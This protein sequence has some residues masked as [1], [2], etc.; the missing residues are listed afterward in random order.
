MFGS[1][2]PNPRRALRLQNKGDK[3]FQ[4]E[5]FERALEFY[6]KS[7]KWNPER[8]EIYRKLNSTLE[9]ID[10]E[11]SQEDFEES[12]SWT[13]RQQE[14]ENP[15]LKW[16]YQK[17]SVEYQNI[18]KL[19]R[20]LMLINN[21]EEEQKILVQILEYEEKAALPL[22]DFLLSMKIAAHKGPE[23]PAEEP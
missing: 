15:E 12:L 14:L 9:K 17:F 11:W 23:E 16:V 13:M 10:R 6:R 18:H 19:L 2:I 20:Q 21:P 22:L 5:K 4:N 1:K 8:P 7:Q 3:F